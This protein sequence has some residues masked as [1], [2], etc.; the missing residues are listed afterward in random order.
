L[1]LHFILFLTQT[2]QA[3]GNAQIIEL[4]AADKTFSALTLEAE[5]EA[6]ASSEGLDVPLS[7]AW[8][9]DLAVAI[10]CM[11]FAGLMSG[12]TIGL[13]SI[14]RLTL[15]IDA[16]TDPVA[17]R[18]SKKIFPVIDKHHWM[19]VTLLLCNACAMETLPLFLD[20]MVPEL[21]A[22]ILSVTA[23]LFVGEIIPQAICTGPSQLKIAYYMC[24]IV[25]AIMWITCPISWPIAKLLDKL[26]G[27]H[28][29]QRFDNDQLKNLILLHSK[30]AL[31]GLEHGVPDDVE[32]LDQD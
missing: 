6:E 14:D 20:K 23:V 32:G 28:E 10:F 21:Y 13:A 8:W 5:A 7:G 27:E 31:K 1:P 24:P 15:E 4:I 12:L 18:M 16:R 2:A 30:A 3:S 9:T 19:L 11:C 25:T 17:N 29:I 26:M 22:I